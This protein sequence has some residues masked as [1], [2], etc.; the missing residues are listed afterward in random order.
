VAT[1]DDAARVR[2]IAADTIRALE[3][4]TAVADARIAELKVRTRKPHACHVCGT[5]TKE[6]GQ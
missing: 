4:A 6:D 3:E 5:V 2:L 1:T